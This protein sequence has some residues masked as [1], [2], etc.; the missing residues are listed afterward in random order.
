MI[1]FTPGCSNTHLPSF[2]KGYDSIKGK[3]VDQIVCLRSA[4]TRMPC[5]GAEHGSTLILNRTLGLCIAHSNA[6]SVLS[7]C[8]PCEA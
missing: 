1:Q 3:G 8:F 6:P 2:L 4:H 5:I 7:P